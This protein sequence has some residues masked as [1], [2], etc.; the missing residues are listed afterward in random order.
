M[1]KH[2]IK[3]SFELSS[4]QEVFMLTAVSGRQ[5]IVEKNFLIEKNVLFFILKL[6]TLY[7]SSA[8]EKCYAFSLGTGNNSFAKVN[9][10]VSKSV[11]L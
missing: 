10:P 9:A 3:G 5:H 7:H 11:P 1:C 8:K 2:V 6:T 4:M